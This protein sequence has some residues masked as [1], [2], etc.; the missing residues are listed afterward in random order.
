MGKVN[1]V[2][3]WMFLIPAAMLIITAGIAVNDRRSDV[4]AGFPENTAE[5]GQIVVEE[6]EA[7]KAAETE[8]IEHEQKT[9][10]ESI[11]EAG[12]TVER[13][14]IGS[15]SK[16]DEATRAVSSPETLAS[17]SESEVEGNAAAE[18]ADKGGVP[19]ESVV[20]TDATAGE[21]SFPV[22]SV[23]GETMD[24]DLQRFLWEELKIEGI[25][26]WMPYAILTAYQESQFNVYDITNG[27]DY[28]IYQFYMVDWPEKCARYGYPG[29]D[30]FNPY[31]QI[32]V[33]V[34]QTA[35]RLKN[36]GCSIEDTIS[37]HMMSDWCEYNEKYVS[38][39][40]GHT[41]EQIR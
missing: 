10:E 33:Y 34:K 35:N 21:D 27:R 23:D 40:L 31:V 24:L 28:G 25:E 13:N 22:Y 1:K 36:L 12:T 37:R 9:G 17:E 5:A 41:I 2:P 29:A 7:V 14:Q 38:D 11:P 20:G 8:V 4:S 26:W 32:I 6:T 15:R 19:G 16:D 30:I 39:V 18:E 3:D